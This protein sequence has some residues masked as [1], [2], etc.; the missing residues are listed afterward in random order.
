MVV[1]L[2]ACALEVA[3]ADDDVEGARHEPNDNEHTAAQ[4][5][6]K[7]P[8]ADPDRSVTFLWR[9]PTIEREMWIIILE[10]AIPQSDRGKPLSGHLSNESTL[11]GQLA[12][13]CSGGWNTALTLPSALCS[14]SCSIP[15]PAPCRHVHPQ[16][17]KTVCVD[18]PSGGTA[19]IRLIDP[20]GIPLAYPAGNRPLP[21]GPANTWAI[22]IHSSAP[23][24]V[25]VSDVSATLR[26]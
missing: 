24:P 22:P 7:R 1:V 14:A 10:I 4:T 19:R 6:N 20:T 17:S 5:T 15:C 3:G 16:Y 23:L 25:T 12:A 18:A 8:R 2:P 13:R 9:I 11:D 26:R 21:G